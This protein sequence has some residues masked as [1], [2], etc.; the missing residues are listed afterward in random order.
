MQRAVIFEI[1]PHQLEL[2]ISPVCVSEQKQGP[3]GPA[4]ICPYVVPDSPLVDFSSDEILRDTDLAA[5]CTTSLEQ[6][7]NEEFEECARHVLRQL[8][9]VCP[10]K[11]TRYVPADTKSFVV[12]G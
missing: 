5:S 2:Y 3:G 4:R 10:T 7:R 8:G 12:S 11:R 9:N 1:P 6:T